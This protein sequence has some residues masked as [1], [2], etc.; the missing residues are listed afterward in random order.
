[1][2]FLKFYPKVFLELIKENRFSL[3]R[4]DIY[5]AIDLYLNLYHKLPWEDEENIPPEE[6]GFWGRQKLEKAEDFKE[7]EDVS[8][9]I[10]YKGELY[11][12]EI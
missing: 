10:L 5:K 4:D 11:R 9:L 1:M 6:K 2:L 3:L 8:K 7:D 12:L